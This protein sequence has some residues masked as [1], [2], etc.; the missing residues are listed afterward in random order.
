MLFAVE[1]DP[2]R[3]LLRGEVSE[4]R[5]LVTFSSSLPN[6]PH[7]D[8]AG[9]WIYNFGRRSADDSFPQLVLN[10]Q[11]TLWFALDIANLVGP[12]VITSLWRSPP[13]NDTPRDQLVKDAP[14]GKRFGV[15]GG[16]T[17]FHKKAMAVDFYSKAGIKPV[18]LAV[19]LHDA[20]THHMITPGGIGAYGWGVHADWRGFKDTNSG[21]PQ[22]AMFGTRFAEFKSRV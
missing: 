19:R 14:F 18:E 10:L 7:F 4:F 20:M 9:F 3:N 16:A 8:S 11:R 12:I 15:G 13:L 6:D 17:S 2:L 5:K 22:V 1:S 21:T